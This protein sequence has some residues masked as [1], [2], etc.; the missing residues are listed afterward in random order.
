MNEV[1]PVHANPTD[2][3]LQLFSS[4]ILHK[5]DCPL[6]SL[7]QFILLRPKLNA[8][9]MLL[10]DL[11]KFYLWSHNELN[12]TVTLDD[13]KRVTVGEMLNLY[14]EKHYFGEDKDKIVET[15]EA[16]AGTN[17]IY[18]CYCELH[19]PFYVIADNYE[20]YRNAVGQSKMPALTTSTP[21]IEILTTPQGG[22]LLY[23]TIAQIV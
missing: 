15:F 19:Y 4:T 17:T 11:V 5:D 12:Y 23:R 7:Y 14:L 2:F 16:V 3:F 21:L 18:T 9:G 6:Y 20:V 10:P 1:F 8:G 13:A 22:N